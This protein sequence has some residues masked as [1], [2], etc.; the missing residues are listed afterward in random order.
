MKI[1]KILIPVFLATLL[2][3]GCNL[4]LNINSNGNLNKL[5]QVSVNTADNANG[6]ANTN[7]AVEITPEIISTTEGVISQ[8]KNAKDNSILIENVKDLCWQDM[9]LFAQPS[10]ELLILTPLNPGSDKPLTDLYNL[11]LTKKTCTKSSVS[12]ELSDFGVRVLSPNQ[13]KLAVA[14]E[15]NE[16]KILK[17]VDLVN[18]TAKIAVT[19]PEGET[20]NGG[21]GALSNHFDIKWLDDKTIQYTVFKDT[22]TDYN[23]K[24]PDGIEDVLQVRVLKIE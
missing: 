14:L 21:Y 9:K 2:L 24:A 22:V 4:K 20:L 3:S 8:I 19:L 5:P 13:T 6:A 18:G 12:D 23:A 15:T 10:A 16:A 11:D 17:L 7:S 1:L